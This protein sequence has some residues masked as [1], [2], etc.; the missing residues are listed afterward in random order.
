M[1]IRFLGSGSCD[2]PVFACCVTSESGRAD[3]EV[4][5]IAIDTIARQTGAE[6]RINIIPLL[7]PV[8]AV[9]R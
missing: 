7:N 3:E 6:A 9:G 2:T 1:V 5:S 8:C 4:M